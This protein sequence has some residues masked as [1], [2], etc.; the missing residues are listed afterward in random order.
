MLPLPSLCSTR[1]FLAAFDIAD[2]CSETAGRISRNVL[3][4]V[5]R[6]RIDRTA[7]DLWRVQG[8]CRLRP[9][10]IECSWAAHPLSKRR[11]P[12][13]GIENIGERFSESRDAH[14]SAAALLP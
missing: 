12:F 14:L 13:G 5:A 1:A 8:L 7:K 11:I 4:L 6:D 9:R 2:R 10:R 3:L